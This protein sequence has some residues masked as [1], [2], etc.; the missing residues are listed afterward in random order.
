MFV[1]PGEQ[2][3][4]SKEILIVIMNHVSEEIFP[5]LKLG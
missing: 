3:S 5:I 2:L 1:F 4:T